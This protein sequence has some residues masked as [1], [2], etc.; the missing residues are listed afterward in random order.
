MAVRPP[1]LRKTSWSPD[2]NESTL[3]L[4]INE[5]VS[6]R[7]PR[8]GR[9]A[10]KSTFLELVEH[11]KSFMEHRK[12]KLIPGLL[13]STA[14]DSGN[15]AFANRPKN[16]IFVMWSKGLDRRM[17]LEVRKTATTDGGYVASPLLAPP[18]SWQLRADYHAST[19]PFVAHFESGSCG[20]L[21]ASLSR[22]ARV[23]SNWMVMAVNSYKHVSSLKTPA[24]QNWFASFHSD[25]PSRRRTNRIRRVRFTSDSSHRM[26]RCPYPWRVAPVRQLTDVPRTQFDHR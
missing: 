6:D 12:K 8:S 4:A 3:L 13:V 14:P 16:S 5:I 11:C 18:R 7:V 21:L 20:N 24:I 15:A 2:A 1:A 19:T 22:R 23:F 17:R 25:A 26:L 10:F 9:Q